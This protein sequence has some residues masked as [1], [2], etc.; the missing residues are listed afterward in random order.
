R[1]GIPRVNPVTVDFPA[2]A[3][4]CVAVIRAP[5][6]YGLMGQVEAAIGTEVS[7]RGDRACGRGRADHFAV[8]GERCFELD[9]HFQVDLTVPVERHVPARSRDLLRA[10][11]TPYQAAGL[12]HDPGEFLRAGPTAHDGKGLTAALLEADLVCHLSP[13]GAGR[14]WIPWI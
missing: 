1:V 3:G 10:D 2:R 5:L 13:S 8:P 11:D 7:R 6:A 9:A 12:G 4:Q 14:R